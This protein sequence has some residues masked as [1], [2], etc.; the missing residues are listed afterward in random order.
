VRVAD[1][2][3]YYESHGTGTPLLLIAGLN[4]DHMLFRSVTARLAERYRVIVF[5]NRGIGRSTGAGSPF[6]M[7]TLAD[8]A[9]G[10]L[11]ALGIACSHVLGVSL[12]GRIAAALTLRHPHL[13]RGLVL[14]S[15]TME[16]PPHSWHQRWVGFL[17][18]LPFVRHGNPYAVVMRQRAAS[19]AFNCTERL[20]EIRVPTL[21]LHGRRDRLAPPALVERMHERIAGSRLIAFGGGHLFF[22]LRGREFLDAV[23]AFLDAVDRGSTEDVATHGE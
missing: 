1:I 15:T 14:V 6:S 2:T 18:R 13:V 4:S 22:L 5:D 7:E 8:D 21:I 11:Q 23:L 9:A 19:R 17:L 3:L 16:P 10:L 20:H 12:G